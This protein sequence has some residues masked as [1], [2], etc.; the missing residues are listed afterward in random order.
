MMGVNKP[1]RQHRFWFVLIL[2]LATIFSLAGDLTLYA[3]LPVNAGNLMLTLG[4]IGVIL[5][6]NRFIRLGSNPITGWLLDQGR[7]RPVFLAGLVLGVVS[8]LT[9]ALTE[10]FLILFIGRLIWGFAWSFINISGKTMVIDITDREDRGRYLG[11]LNLLISLGLMLNPLLGGILAEGFGFRPTM[12]T[13]VSLTALGFLMA[14]I[15]LPESGRSPGDTRTTEY[16]TLELSPQV[17]PGITWQDIKDGFDIS[18]L[19]GGIWLVISLSFITA[20]SGFGLV[21]STAGLFLVQEA[22]KGMIFFGN[23]IGAASL[24]GV[25]LGL[26]A[27]LIA[28]TSP[29]VGSVSDHHTSRWPMVLL[30]LV[31]G[32]LGMAAFGVLPAL[33]A[34]FLGVGMIAAAEGSLMSVLPALVG[35]MTSP[36]KLGKTIGLMYMAGDLGSA[37]APLIVY[38]LVDQV[39]LRMA[40][41]ASGFAFG[42]GAVAVLIRLYRTKFERSI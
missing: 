40:Y 8:T 29:L 31:L 13:A 4:Q 9:Y 32:M 24:T 34:V 27:L 35:D 37:L 38:A 10:Q 3:T 28:V 42:I 30:G 16:L 11:Y 1:L 39:S 20:F 14:L 2:G 25:I 17:D 26:R 36:G 12:L 7:R 18:G 19:G 22:D 5:S 33:I 21:M 23:L 6:A 41:L 15:F